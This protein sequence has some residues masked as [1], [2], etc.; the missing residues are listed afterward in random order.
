MLPTVGMVTLILYA[1]PVAAKVTVSVLLVVESE[2]DHRELVRGACSLLEECKADV[3]LILNK[4]RNY[5]PDR[6]QQRLE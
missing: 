6:L 2:K 1:C 5:V 4:N 3:A